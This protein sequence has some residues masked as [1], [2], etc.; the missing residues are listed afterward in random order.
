MIISLNDGEISTFMG[1]QDV[2]KPTPLVEFALDS[3]IL[4]QN[5]TDVQNFD[6]NPF[7]G[8]PNERYFYFQRFLP[9]YKELG[10]QV[11]V[12]A[13]YYNELS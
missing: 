1:D 9:P 7:M 5:I 13:T 3:L 2:S 6:D 10:A 11:R 12:F 8:V 4:H